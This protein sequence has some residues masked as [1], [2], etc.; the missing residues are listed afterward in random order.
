MDSGLLIFGALTYL[1]VA[2]WLV[3]LSAKRRKPGL[4]RACVVTATFSTFFSV[5]VL[6]Q[7]GVVP[8]PALTIVV[9]CLLG[10][11]TKMYGSWGGLVWGFLP[12]LVQWIL[13]L[14]IFLVFQK[15]V[16][17]VGRKSTSEV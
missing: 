3:A 10:D 15:L 2:T 1:A 6:V 16:K 7:D 17:I 12:M 8:V 11:C 5:S 9:W 14:I 4:V 13:L